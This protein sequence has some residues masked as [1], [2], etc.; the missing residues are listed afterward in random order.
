VDKY[1]SGCSGTAPA[2]ETVIKLSD[3]VVKMFPNIVNPLGS[4]RRQGSN[5]N[6]LIEA[7]S[8]TEAGVYL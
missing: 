7:G 6:V 3:Q 2:D 8:P 4:N 1:C 5:S